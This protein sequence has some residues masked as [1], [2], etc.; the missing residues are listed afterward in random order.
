[1]RFLIGV[2]CGFF[3]TVYFTWQLEFV[4]STWRAVVG[5]VPGW[6]LWAAAYRDVTYLIHDWK[7]IQITTGVMCI[8][9]LLTWW[10][11]TYIQIIVINK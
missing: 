5:A 9:F 2:S 10:Y 7:Y 4:S 6:A 8:P 11:V 1:M 3:L